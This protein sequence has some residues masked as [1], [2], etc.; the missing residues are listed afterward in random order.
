MT[1]PTKPIRTTVAIGPTTIVGWISAVLGL[2]PIVVKSVEEGA[3]AL[4]GPEK[5][6][7]I[8]GIV[9]AGITQIG[10]YLQSLGVKR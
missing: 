8:F 6:L 10:R 3:V 2:L 5:Y 1:T 7:A 9:M 4:A